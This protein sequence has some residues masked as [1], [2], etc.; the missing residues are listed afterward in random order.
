[1]IPGPRNLLMSRNG[2]E[3]VGY[4]SFLK[5]P[6]LKKHTMYW[7]KNTT[8]YCFYIG[9]RVCLVSN[10]DEVSIDPIPS[11]IGLARC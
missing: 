7:T 3:M 6:R 1:M 4:S 11:R 10:A 2:V 9:A 8:Y 5:K